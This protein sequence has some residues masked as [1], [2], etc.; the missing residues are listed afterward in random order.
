MEVCIN[1]FAIAKTYEEVRIYPLNLPVRIPNE[2]LVNL[3]DA[4]SSAWWEGGF[5]SLQDSWDAGDGYLW[6]YDNTAWTLLPMDGP[7]SDPRESAAEVAARSL[8]EAIPG[9]YLISP[10]PT[11]LK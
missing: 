7:T 1:F 10:T 8:H 6:G 2:W 3:D 9:R 11:M 5:P 4:D